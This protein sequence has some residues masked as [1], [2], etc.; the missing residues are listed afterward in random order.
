MYREGLGVRSDAVVAYSWIILAASAEPPHPEAADE[1]DAMTEYMPKNLIAEGQRLAR[2]WKPGM[3]LGKSKPKPVD[4][5]SLQ[6]AWAAKVGQAV[7]SK[8]AEQPTGQ[9]PARPEVMP[10]LTTCNTRCVNGDCYRT[11][12][13]GRKVHFQA[14]QKWNPIDNQFEWD[15][16]NC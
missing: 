8:P 5:A 11:Y 9:Y 6:A 16:G 1:R 4:V 12:G 3:S 2:E 14:R 10:G 15:S 7:A 13:D